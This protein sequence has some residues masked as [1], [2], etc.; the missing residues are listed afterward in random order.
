[1]SFWYNIDR[2]WRSH[3]NLRTLYLL[4]LGQTVSFVLAMASFTSSLVSSLGN[5]SWSA[6]VLIILWFWRYWMLWE[7]GC[8]CWRA[9]YTILLQ[10][11]GLSSGVRHHFAV[12]TPETAGILIFF[13]WWFWVIC[14]KY[15]EHLG[16]YG[17]SGNE[18]SSIQTNKKD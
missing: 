5:L 1:M 17:A 9:P 12:Q 14:Y 13:H 8:R 3:A 11:L 15:L 2:W 6:A 18:I 10:L 16:F 7:S 4:L